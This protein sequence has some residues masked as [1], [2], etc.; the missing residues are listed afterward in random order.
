MPHSEPTAGAISVRDLG[1]PARAVTALTRVGVTTVEALAGMS[2]RD[3]TRVDGLGAGMIAA[4]REV[5]PEPTAALPFPPPGTPVAVNVR[6]APTPAP[7]PSSSPDAEEEGPVAPPI[8]SFASLRAAQHRR[9]HDVLDHTLFSARPA[10][11]PVAAAP[12]SRPPNTDDLLRLLVRLAR[13]AATG[14]MGL[15]L[16]PLRKSRTACR[17]LARHLP[18]G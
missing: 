1:L 4:I 5:V 13:G 18:V 15:W 12:V 10:L 7:S 14:P 3:L 17:H 16:W 2:R 8:P 11:Q 9:P 6:P